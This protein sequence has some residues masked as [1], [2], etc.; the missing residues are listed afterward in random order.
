MPVKGGITDY[1]MRIF[2]SV[3]IWYAK[4]CL[5]ISW[6]KSIPSIGRSGGSERGR[7]PHGRA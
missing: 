3:L 5:Y 6:C 1:T 4:K 2:S 7:K